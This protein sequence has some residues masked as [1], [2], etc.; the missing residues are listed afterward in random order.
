MDLSIYIHN[1]MKGLEL[2]FYKYLYFTP[3]KVAAGVLTF[4]G[5]VCVFNPN[6]GRGL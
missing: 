2:V 1:I 6:V 5:I 4:H 3:S